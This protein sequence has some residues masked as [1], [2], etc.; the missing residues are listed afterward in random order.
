MWRACVGALRV[1]GG[2][3]KKWAETCGLGLE[4]GIAG[5]GDIVRYLAGHGWVDLHGMKLAPRARHGVGRWTPAR[6][7]DGV[8]ALLAGHVAGS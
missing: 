4:V 5:T 2:F 3:F 7:A 1:L 8:P 6:R